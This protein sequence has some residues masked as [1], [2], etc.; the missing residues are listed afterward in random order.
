MQTSVE[1]VDRDGLPLRTFPVAEGRWRL[2]ADLDDIDPRFIEAL[3]LIEDKRFFDHS[4]VDLTAVLRATRD[5]AVRGRIVSG[6]S[7]ITMQTARM[8][9]PRPRTL[10]SKGIETLRALQIERRLSKEE[11]L[12]LYLTL[13]P[14]G[15]NLE[16][17]RA[18][19]FAYFGRDTHAL[20]DAQ[21]A[22]LLALPQSPEVR[23]PDRHAK[24]ALSA[25][26]TI[27]K[28][29]ANEGFFSQERALAAASDPLPTER[30]AFPASA[31]HYAESTTQLYT[32]QATIRTTIDGRL[33][34]SAERRLHEAVADAGP[35]VQA[36]ALIIETENRDIVASVGS[37]SRERSGGW[38]DLTRRVR[39]P[40]STLKPFVFGL[41][42][43]EG[44]VTPETR[45]DDRASL[46][47]L[48]A[49]QNFSRT[50]HGELTV[51]TALQHSL[52]VPA[53]LLLDAV[54][55]DRF[56]G[57]LEVA[58]I[59]AEI[60]DIGDNGAG[61]AVALGGMGVNAQDLA[62]LYAA[63]ADN[64]VMKPLETT[65]DGVQIFSKQ[66]AERL[67]DV[68]R[69]SPAPEG[70]MPAHLTKDAPNIA[71]KTGTSYGFRDAW[72]VG[73]SESH[74]VVVW[75]GRPDGA[76]RPGVTGRDAALP[77]VFDIF[78]DIDPAQGR[79][80]QQQ[81]N[82]R[83]SGPQKFASNTDP[84]IIF[85]AD[86]ATLYQRA[87]DRPFVLAGRGETAL[88]WY[89][90]GEMLVPDNEGNVIWRPGEPGFY[91]ITAVDSLGRR[92]DAR[93]RV[94]SVLNRSLSE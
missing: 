35:S 21:I 42:M 23:R 67:L 46:F 87:D 58:E 93:V 65:S 25:R 74:V 18:A 70:R 49:P 51:A 92:D 89:A 50:F 2:S 14:Y 31:W 38:L 56:L 54:G 4:G 44:L 88:R 86:K 91:A 3:L 30:Q 16:G 62:T 15:G 20:T 78:D 52:N 24:H 40:G 76:P 68:L 6:A 81:A 85:P 90:N 80:P 22:L 82:T 7:T 59:T 55:T 63:L 37:V 83:V 8:L 27:L 33:Q 39:S 84:E 47:G 10:W 12:E 43:E 77:I 13:T 66:T 79:A 94:M 5:N 45:L 69:K 29:L 61:L 71:F 17:L 19:S 41:A 28:R 34:L 11:I 73:V 60:P 72:A 32:D 53:V 26:E 36:A 64:G 9:E 75:V 57:V 1:V 48:Y